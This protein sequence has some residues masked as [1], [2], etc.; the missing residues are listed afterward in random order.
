[1]GIKEDFKTKLENICNVLNMTKEFYN[2]TSHFHN[3]KNKEERDFILSSI[4]SNQ[5][6]FIRY[7]FFRNTIIELAKLYS[8]S[9]N[10]KYSLIHFIRNCKDGYYSKMNIDRDFLTECDFFLINNEN[11][12]NRIQA[13]RSN[14]YAHSSDYNKDIDFEISFEEIKNL[15]NF[16]ERLINFLFDDH[17]N[18][19]VDFTSPTSEDLELNFISLLVEG[20]KQR[21]KKI[22]ED[23][24]I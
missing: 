6:S 10:D 11:L 7:S 12:I 23:S 18:L 19:Y 4:Y 21:I 17:Y 16:S 24:D 13:A 14:H 20:E 22:Y 1:M 2:F 3:F 9:K 5:V 8:F 15:I